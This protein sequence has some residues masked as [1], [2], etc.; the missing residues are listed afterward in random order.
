MRTF[1]CVP[2]YFCVGL[3][4]DDL[5]KRGRKRARIFPQNV[6]N[7][8]LY[9]PLICGHSDIIIYHPALK[10]MTEEKDENLTTQHS[11]ALCPRSSYK[12]RKPNNIGPTICCAITRALFCQTIANYSMQ[13]TSTSTPPPTITTTPT[14]H[15]STQ[16]VHEYTTNTNSSFNILFESQHATTQHKRK[17]A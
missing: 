4:C 1:K 12:T 5:Y 15:K 6:L 16:H 2:F 17:T 11:H 9:A 8:R 10:K 7:W 13:Q 14:C 3:F